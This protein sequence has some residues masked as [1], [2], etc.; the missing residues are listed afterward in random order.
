MLY[1]IKKWFSKHTQLLIYAA[2]NAMK[3]HDRANAHML[4]THMLVIVLDPAPSGTHGEFVYESA[5][6]GE[7]GD[8]KYGLTADTRAAL[9][10]LPAE[11]GRFWLIMYVRSGTA[12]YLAPISVEL[13]PALQGVWVFGPPD[14]DWKG[15]LERAINKTLEAKDETRIQLLQMLS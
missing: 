3:L 5:A 4:K 11:G 15:V 10:D 12:A 1:D 13:G 9:A 8:P 7:T 6:L 2:M 14:N